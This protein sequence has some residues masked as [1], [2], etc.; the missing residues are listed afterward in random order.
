MNRCPKCNKYSIDYDP[1][2]RVHRCMIDGCSCVIINENSYSILKVDSK[3]KTINR[4][5]IENGEEVE[6]LKKYIMC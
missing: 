1:Y 3:N 6:I 5:K 2:R 4:I